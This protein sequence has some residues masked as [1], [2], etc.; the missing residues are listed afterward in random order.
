MEEYLDMEISKIVNCLFEKLDLYNIDV[1]MNREE[2]SSE[3][4][5]IYMEIY[6]ECEKSLLEV[7]AKTILKY[8]N[9]NNFDYIFGVK[10]QNIIASKQNF[11]NKEKHLK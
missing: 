11:L 10:V 1:E 7:K 9:I 3:K 5:K 8:G 4:K 6:S 2:L